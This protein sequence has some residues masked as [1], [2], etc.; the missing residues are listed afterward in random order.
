MFTTTPFSFQGDLMF[1]EPYT[2]QNRGYHIILI[3]ININNR[4]LYV[5]PLKRKTQPALI[6]A[7]KDILKKTKVQ[8]IGFDGE[9]GFGSD[10]FQFLKSKKIDFYRV[11][12][13]AYIAERMIRTL[14]LMINKH[15]EADNTT[16][17][18][19][20][21]DTLVDK[22]NHTKH[23]TIKK[24][25]MH[26]TQED[27]VRFIREQQKKTLRVKRDFIPDLK[28]GDE[29]R[30]RINKSIFDKEGRNFSKVVY[31]IKALIGN[32]YQLTDGKTY[33]HQDLQKSKFID[34]DKQAKEEQDEPEAD[35]VDD[36]ISKHKSQVKFKREKIPAVPMTPR[37][38]R[39]GKKL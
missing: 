15:M 24:A 21:L 33:R 9:S 38:L 34:T 8:S 14:K 31:K 11:S 2:N 36:A 3:M 39:S 27:E 13:K 4:Q 25:P 12:N 22:Y 26:M 16:N 29:V 32:R 18:I 35:H 10:M 7:M 19:D 20:S 6:E 37:T 17:W 30:H 1:I 28:V 5:V 23:S